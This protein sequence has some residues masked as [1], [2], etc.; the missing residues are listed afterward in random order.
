MLD[1]SVVVCGIILQLMS[2]MIVRFRVYC[3]RPS[4]PEAEKMKNYNMTNMQH[5]LETEHEDE[6][7]TLTAKEK[8]LE[9][10]KDKTTSVGSS[11][12]PLKVLNG[13]YRYWHRYQ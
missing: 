1:Q 4:F 5:H 11:S 2:R 7:A 13:H 9:R 3:A 12:Q 10:E 6:L 8:E